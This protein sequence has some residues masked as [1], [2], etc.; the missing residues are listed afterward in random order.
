MPSR[1]RS[2]RSRSQRGFGNSEKP[3]WLRPILEVAEK[4][5][6]TLNEAARLARNGYCADAYTSLVDGEQGYGMV[7][8]NVNENG[9]SQLTHSIFH[10][11]FK[12]QREARIEV[13]ERC[14][15]AGRRSKRG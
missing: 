5:T 13:R 12:A 15:V 11:A 14:V 6:H 7:Q 1:K 8:R 10:R 9:A 4:A 3:Q 2:I